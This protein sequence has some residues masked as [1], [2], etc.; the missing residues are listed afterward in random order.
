MNFNQFLKK[1]NE[2]FINKFIK[3]NLSD[4]LKFIYTWD[5]ELLHLV[6]NSIA[7]GWESSISNNVSTE[8]YI[9]LKT[10]NKEKIMQTRWYKTGYEKTSEG[11]ETFVDD[12]L[13][14]YKYLN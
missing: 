14:V 2:D 11:F 9:A 10:K 12:L 6:L 5:K 4:K 7:S 8:L 13:I 1:S 3:S